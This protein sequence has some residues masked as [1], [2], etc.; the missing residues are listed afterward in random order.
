M[1]V[2][3]QWAKLDRFI[4]H[5]CIKWTQRG[6]VYPGW[7]AL[8]IQYSIHI[9]FHNEDYDKCCNC[10]YYCTCMYMYVFS[11]MFDQNVF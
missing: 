10:F 5:P 4:P 8:I 1:S 2:W 9:L 6:L 11:Q 7:I 3:S